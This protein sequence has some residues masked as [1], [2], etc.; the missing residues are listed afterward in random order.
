MIGLRNTSQLFA[1]SWNGSEVEVTGPVVPA[2]SWTH[3]AVT[4]HLDRE[5]RLYANES[6]SNASDPFSFAGSN[7]SNYLFVGSSLNATDIPS[8]PY[9]VGQYWG[10]VDELRV[11]SRELTEHEINA[12]ANV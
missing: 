6:L 3:V 12:L 1:L 7:G 8:R 10:A 11:Y 2:N 9:T 5:L 4:Y